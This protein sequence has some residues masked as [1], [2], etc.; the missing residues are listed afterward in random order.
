[1]AK[2]KTEDVDGIVVALTMLVDNSHGLKGETVYVDEQYVE[3]LLA[4]GRAVKATNGKVN[5]KDESEPVE[6]SSV[7]LSEIQDGEPEAGTSSN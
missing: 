5:T 4:K 6:E 1:M 3:G 7:E 2:K